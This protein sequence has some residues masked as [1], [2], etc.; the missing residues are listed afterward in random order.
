M[1]ED[2]GHHCCEDEDEDDDFG[3]CK[4]GGGVIQEEG[5]WGWGR[6]W[7]RLLQGFCE[8]FCSESS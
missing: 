7:P 1:V 6:R 4:Q 5:K 8:G 3:V 2:R